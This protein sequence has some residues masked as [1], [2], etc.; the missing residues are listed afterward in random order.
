MRVRATRRILVMWLKHH[1]QELSH[2]FVWFKKMSSNWSNLLLSLG[3]MWNMVQSH[4]YSAVFERSLMISNDIMISI[5][6]DILNT[7]QG[8]SPF[9]TGPMT[10]SCLFSWPMTRNV[11]LTICLPSIQICSCR[12]DMGCESIVVTVTQQQLNWF[13]HFYFSKNI[14]GISVEQIKL[15]R[16]HSISCILS[17]LN[18]KFCCCIYFWWKLW[19]FVLHSSFR[20]IWKKFL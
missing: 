3:T 15:E 11:I 18:L 19:W 10:R 4:H 1:H 14:T 16:Y 7:K 5:S 8:H 17:Y 12:E 6:C 2:R 9:I 13:Y 20:Q